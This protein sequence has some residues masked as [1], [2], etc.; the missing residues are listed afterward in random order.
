MSLEIEPVNV[1]EVKIHADTFS[2]L[3]DLLMQHQEIDNL[4]TNKLKLEVDPKFKKS[5]LDMITIIGASE[6]SPLRSIVDGIQ[7]IFDDGKIDVNDI[8]VIIKVMTDV[9]NSNKKLFADVKP[10][11]QHISVVMKIIILL[12][13]RLELIKQN[14]KQEELLLRIID[15]SLALLSTSVDLEKINWSKC[16]CC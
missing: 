6:Q 11:F 3:R 16:F 9:L 14:E 13:A 15:S 10:N 12:L 5:V 7:K 4:F 2:L 8:P 1:K